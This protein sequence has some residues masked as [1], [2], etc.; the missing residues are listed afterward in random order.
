MLECSTCRVKC[1]FRVSGCELPVVQSAF[2]NLPIGWLGARGSCGRVESPSRPM[3]GDS[4]AG[5]TLLCEGGE[6]RAH[7]LAA[8]SGGHACESAHLV[9]IPALP[10]PA[11]GPTERARGS[12]PEDPA[13][14]A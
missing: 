10:V 9:C 8:V 11:F 3:S 13:S 14:R 6:F 2:V 12:T 7:R 5:A 1:L 4:G